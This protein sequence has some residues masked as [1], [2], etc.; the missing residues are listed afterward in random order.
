MNGI[1]KEYH[2]DGTYS[3][4]HYENG[5]KNGTATRFFKTGEKAIIWEFKNDII[6]S[7]IGYYPTGEKNVD[8]GYKNGIQEGISTEYYESG[9][10]IFEW[11]FK[12]GQLKGET[13]EYCKNGNVKNVLNY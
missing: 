9:E 7:G 11:R 2:K 13:I 4:W 6:I 8:I 1:T 10:K 3:E 12:N 5:E